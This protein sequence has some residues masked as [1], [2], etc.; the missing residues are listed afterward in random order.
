V[1]PSIPT[2][3]VVRVNGRGEALSGDAC[4]FTYFGNRLGRAC[5]GHGEGH[6]IGRHGERDED[7]HRG[8]GGPPAAD[9][10]ATHSM[11]R[12][13]LRS[14]AAPPTSGRY[15]STRNRSLLGTMVPIGQP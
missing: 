9:D 13:T 4:V 3:G 10:E 7:L 14:N 8:T 11:S 5:V 6:L 15:H 12:A 2:K 1:F